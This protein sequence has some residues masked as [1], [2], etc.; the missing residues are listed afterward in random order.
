MLIT[1]SPFILDFRSEDDLKSI[2][3]FSWI[4]R[5]VEAIQEARGVSVAGAGS[6]IID[7][8][9]AEEVNGS[10]RLFKRLVVFRSLE[11]EAV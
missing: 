8:G 3:S 9:G 4:T 7:A 1:H 2:I 10:L 6:C 5:I 11:Q